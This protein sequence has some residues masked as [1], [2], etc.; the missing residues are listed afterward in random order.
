M[1]KRVGESFR[2]IATFTQRGYFPPIDVG[3]PE[4]M[5]K[6]LVNLLVG[7]SRMTNILHFVR[8][9]HRKNV[10]QYINLYVLLTHTST[11]KIRQNF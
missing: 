2:C 7:T 1:P 9:H 3:R 5:I 8:F 6:L 11:T 4:I 10:L